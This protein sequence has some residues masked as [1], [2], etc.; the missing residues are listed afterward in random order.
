MNL[1]EPDDGLVLTSNW[2]LNYESNSWDD[3]NT[4]SFTLMAVLNDYPSIQAAE[5]TFQVI[6]LTPCMGAEI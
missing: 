3:I 1:T 6:V 4:Y 5:Q 2:K